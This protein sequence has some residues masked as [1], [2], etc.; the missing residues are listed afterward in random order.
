MLQIVAPYDGKI[1]YVNYLDS[2]IWRYSR[3]RNCFFAQQDGIVGAGERGG[4][5][6]ESRNI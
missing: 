2:A 4:S 1:W 6:K 5:S 3:Y